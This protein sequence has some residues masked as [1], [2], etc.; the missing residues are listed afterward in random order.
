MANKIHPTQNFVL[1]EFRS[2][3]GGVIVAPDQSR[4]PTDKI[5]VLAT[6]PDVPAIPAIKP[7][8][9]ILVRGDTKF[10]G[11]T[12]NPHQFL[13]DSRWIA[14]VIEPCDELPTDAEIDLMA[15]GNS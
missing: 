7:G 10:Y 12:Q 5:T 3:N 13:V 2:M 8:D 6:G 4:N 14:A 11:A 9:V 15:A 1:V